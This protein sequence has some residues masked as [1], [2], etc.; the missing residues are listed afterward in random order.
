MNLGT[1]RTI[2]LPAS[3][4]RACPRCGGSGTVAHKH[5]LGGTCFRCMGSGFVRKVAA[6]ANYVVVRKP[7]PR[8]CANCGNTS[9]TPCCF[10]CRHCGAWEHDCGG[11]GG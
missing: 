7:E 8:P 2:R 1:V 3:E 9:A 10:E 4:L 11:C 5:V 6:R